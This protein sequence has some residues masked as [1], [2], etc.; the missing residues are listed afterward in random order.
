MSRFSAH[1]THAGGRG[2]RLG[3]PNRRQI[4]V[5][6]LCPPMRKVL[7]QAELGNTSWEVEV[8]EAASGVPSLGGHGVL[9]A[10]AQKGLWEG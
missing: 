2:C 6:S 9:S 1:H 5:S 7:I 8:M 4:R 3:S 10:P